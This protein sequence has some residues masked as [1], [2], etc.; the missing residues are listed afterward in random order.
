[1]FVLL[2][3]ELKSLN[4]NNVAV[5]EGFILHREEISRQMYVLRIFPLIV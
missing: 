3:K 2:L 1:M 5:D 4:S